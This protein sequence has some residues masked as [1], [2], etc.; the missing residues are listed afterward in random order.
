[1]H[2]VAGVH[3]VVSAG[4]VLTLG[5]VMMMRLQCVISAHVLQRLWA[6]QNAPP[7]GDWDWH[8]GHDFIW[9]A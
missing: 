7:A 5:R 2:A 4:G 3:A 9:A 6:A 1:M 8:A